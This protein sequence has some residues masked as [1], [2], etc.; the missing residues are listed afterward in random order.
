VAAPVKNEILEPANSPAADPVDIL[1]VDDQPARLLAYRAILAPLAENLIEASS[2]AEALKHLMERECALILLD[3]NMPVMDGFETASLIHQHPRFEK[4]P[5]I[6][7]TAVNVSDM[8]RMRGYKLGAVDYVTVP[9]IPEILRSKVVVLAELVAAHAVHV[10]DVDRGDEDDRRLLE[11]RMLV[12]HARGLEAVHA[13]H[14][15]V[16]QDQRALALHQVLERLRARARFDEILGERREDRPVGEQARRLV[17]DE[18]DVDGID[19]GAGKSVCHRCS[20]CRRT[21]RS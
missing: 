15:D 20:H 8:D 14:V 11:A 10:G 9:I 5:I 6:F 19:L 17:V 1:L 7:V 2:G 13:G 21:P 12:D 16:E 3:V 4:T 18:Q